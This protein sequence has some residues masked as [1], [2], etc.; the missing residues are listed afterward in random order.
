MAPRRRLKPL[1]MSRCL[2]A[3]DPSYWAAGMAVAEQTAVRGNPG[4][5]LWLND[6]TILDQDALSRLLA[7]ADLH[8]GAIV[9]G[10]TRDPLS[11][12]LTYGGRLQDQQMARATFRA[13]ARQRCGSVSRH[14]QR[15]RRSRFRSRCSAG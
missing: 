12:D 11:G 10:A 1:R 3:T 14:F 5:L 2:K 4:F 7:T 15:E 6:D 9:V 8:P 13:P